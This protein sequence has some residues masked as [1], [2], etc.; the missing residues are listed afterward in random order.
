[1]SQNP[2]QQYSTSVF[3]EE[4]LAFIEEISNW[5]ARHRK[6]VFVGTTAV[7]IGACAIGSAIVNFISTNFIPDIHE[8]PFPGSLYFGSHSPCRPD[9][10]FP[11]GPPVMQEYE[12]F[13]VVAS[14]WGVQIYRHGSVERFCEGPRQ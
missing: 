11:N 13:T 14:Q 9:E 12:G 1:M 10:R 4:A 6:L 2:E 3:S 5:I 7:A 8:G